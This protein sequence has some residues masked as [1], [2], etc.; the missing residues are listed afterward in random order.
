MIRRPPP[1]PDYKI[2]LTYVGDFEY[3]NCVNLKQTYTFYQLDLYR[4][5]RD[6]WVRRSRDPTS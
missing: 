4:S 5:T 2:V 3:F 1:P 6:S